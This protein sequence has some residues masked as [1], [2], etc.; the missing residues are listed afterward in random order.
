MISKIILTKEELFKVI[1]DSYLDGFNYGIE[2]ED[3][4]KKYGNS[5]GKDIITYTKDKIKGLIK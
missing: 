3:I 1:S 5:Q 2:K 4:F